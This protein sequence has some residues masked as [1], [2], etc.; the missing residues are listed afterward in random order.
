M[1]NVRL[2]LKYDPNIVYHSESPSFVRAVRLVCGG[3]FGL[4][5]GLWLLFH[6]GPVSTVTVAAVM[7]GSVLLC[8]GFAAYF[9][10]SFWHKVSHAIRFLV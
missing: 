7:V 4:L 9:G 1:S 3:V 5:P 8:A 6:F 2:Y 10:D